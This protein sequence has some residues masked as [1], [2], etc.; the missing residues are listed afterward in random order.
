MR[1]R[2]YA[3]ITNPFFSGSAVMV[4]GSNFVNFL[5][6][7][8]PMVM[9]RILG[10]QNYG[11]LA[12]LFSVL[13]IVSMIPA[14]LGLVVVKFISSA[15]SEEERKG[16][17]GWFTRRIYL[18][19][20][21]LVILMIIGSF[22]IGDFLKISQNLYIVLISLTMLFTLPA[23]IFRSALQGMLQFSKLLI[24]M[25]SES[26]IK[27]ILGLLFVLLGFSVWGAVWGLLIAVIIGW[28]LARYFVGINLSITN[29]QKPKSK[30]ILKYAIPV[31]IHSVS[32][33]LFYNSDLVLVKHFFTSHQAGL[34]AALSTLGKIVL[35]GTAPVAAVMFPMV[36]KRKSE[37]KSYRKIFA[38]SFGLTLLAALILVIIFMLFPK[39]VIGLIYGESYLVVSGLLVWSGI[40]ILLFTLASLLLNYYLSTGK[41]L[42]V[43]F[44]LIASVGQIIGIWLFHE[45]LFSVLIVSIAVAALLLFSLLVYFGYENKED[46]GY[47]PGL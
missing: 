23:F 41:T 33:T 31:L 8:Y 14:S 34:Y 32:I 13:G 7:L 38:Y 45:S 37:G 5:N 6:S 16:L 46:F 12:S 27:L 35:F 10:P 17:I 2:V 15:K 28:I 47:R 36:S 4:F 22:Y 24:S 3:L 25:V 39:I 9:G 26:A 19:S 44:S 42:V 11:E 1:K 18:A 40:F 43:Y 20:Y 29:D 30:E 21:L